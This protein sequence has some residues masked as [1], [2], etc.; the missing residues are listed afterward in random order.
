MPDASALGHSP[1]LLQYTIDS[2]DDSAFDSFPA[3]ARPF[4]FRLGTVVDVVLQNMVGLDGVCEAHPF[5]LHGHKFWI[6]DWGGGSAATSASSFNSSARASQPLSRDTV[7]LYPTEFSANSG[8]K[9]APGTACGW[10]RL[11]F[12][13]DNAGVWLLHCHLGFHMEMGMMLSFVVGSD[14]LRRSR[15]IVPVPLMPLLGT[16]PMVA[17]ATVLA[18]AVLALVWRLCL[19]YRDWRKVSLDPDSSQI[20]LLSD[21]GE[22]ST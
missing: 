14:E 19:L 6:T 13:A 2:S 3:S 16:V 1:T 22:S 4:V 12:V 20:D 15:P 18:V 7:T 9:G 5:H 8:I 10:V 21:S 17:L 11:R